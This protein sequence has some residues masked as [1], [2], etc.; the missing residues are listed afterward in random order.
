[1]WKWLCQSLV[2]DESHAQMECVGQMAHIVV[3][4]SQTQAMTRR[5]W[6]PF[7][8]INNPNRT[9]NWSRSSVWCCHCIEEGRGRE[10]MMADDEG[11]ECYVEE[12]LERM[13]YFYSSYS[14][15]RS[16]TYKLIH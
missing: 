5:H 4:K 8:N 2:D 1:M 7:A 10:E 16:H 13:V 14:Y 12:A 3:S 9:I 11:G 15:S 6:L